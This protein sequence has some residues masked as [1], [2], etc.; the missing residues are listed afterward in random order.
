[1]KRCALLRGGCEA[2][3]LLKNDKRAAFAVMAKWY[4]ITE[5]FYDANFVAELDRSGYIDRLYEDGAA[6]R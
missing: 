2:V 5:D 6:P 4:G 3:A 1:M